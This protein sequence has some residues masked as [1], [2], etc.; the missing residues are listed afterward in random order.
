M[1]FCV[2]MCS[3]AGRNPAARNIYSTFILRSVLATNEQQRGETNFKAFIEMKK[4]AKIAFGQ[5]F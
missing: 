3:P 4:V 2:N 1:P 5:S